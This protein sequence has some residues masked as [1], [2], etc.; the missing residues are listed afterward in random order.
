MLLSKRK[1]YLSGSDWVINT[2]DYMMKSVTCSGNMSQLVLT[3]EGTVDEKEVRSRLNSFV[4]RFPVVHGSVS[5]DFKLTPYWKIPAR[6]EEDVSIFVTPIE[7]LERQGTLLP[8]LEKSANTNFR[9]NCEHVAFHLFIGNEQSALAMMFDHRLFDARGAEMFLDLFQRSLQAEAPSGD[10]TFISSQELTKWKKKFLAGR[11]VNRRIIA[12]TRSAAP[13]SLPLPTEKGKGYKYQLVTFSADETTAL[14][15]AAYRDAG[16]LMESPYFLSLITQAVHEVFRNRLSNGSSY[17]IPVTVDLRQGKDPL[18]ETFF[19]HLSYLFYQVPVES[20]HDLKGLINSFKQQMY[21][22]VKSGFPKDLAEAS[23]LTRIAPLPLL[24]KLLH[25]PLKGRMATFA[26]SHLGKSAYQSSEFLGR[27]I[28]NIFHMPRVPVP[29]GLGFFS[30]SYNGRLNLI[31]SYL[32][33][34]LTEEDADGLSAA[35][36]KKF[37]RVQ[38]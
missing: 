12:L 9:D 18:Q 1:R 25:I 10:V 34:V 4:K 31:I 2:L 11:S 6:S 19:N 21:D 17:V 29:P 3:L 8:L 32:D 36:Q 37:G 14:Y 20:V 38:K 7:S 27:G 16:Y 30:T 35:I 24:G 5:R 33:G 28:E 22:Q 23:L 26:F 13:A 15:D